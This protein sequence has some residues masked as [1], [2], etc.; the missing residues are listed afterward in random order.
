MFFMKELLLL[1]P[2][3]LLVSLA[4]A[5]LQVSHPSM[6][7]TNHQTELVQSPGA[8]AT[9]SVNISNTGDVR[10]DKVFLTLSFLPSSWYEIGDSK[11]LDIGETGTFAFTV[12]LPEDSSGSLDLDLTAHGIRGFGE[13]TS[14]A[15][16]LKLITSNPTITSVGPTTIPQSTPTAPSEDYFS[17]NANYIAIFLVLLIIFSLAVLFTS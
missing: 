5:Q 3:I 11:P 16:K 10:L 9:Y 4:S 7:I 13:V 14:T 8:T 15:V 1:I 6:N 2:I 17:K 12:K